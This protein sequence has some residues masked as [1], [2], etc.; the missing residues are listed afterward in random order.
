M[1]RHGRQGLVS[2]LLTLLSCVH[3]PREAAGDASDSLLG[4]Q[5]QPTSNIDH[6]IQLTELVEAIENNANGL[7]EA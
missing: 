3:L 1:R 7:A 4:G 6:I 5:Y 2:L